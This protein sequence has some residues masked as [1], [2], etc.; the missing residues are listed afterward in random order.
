MIIPIDDDLENELCRV[1]GPGEKQAGSY[2]PED[3]LRIL[4]EILDFHGFLD[5]VGRLSPLWQW[6]ASRAKCRVN[7]DL[8]AIIGSID[9]TIDDETDQEDQ[10]G[11][12]RGGLLGDAQNLAAFGQWHH[13]RECVERHVE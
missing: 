2:C 10:E 1:Y 13:W 12:D 3:Q 8:V 7:F 4:G 9:D 6:S 5:L 11:D